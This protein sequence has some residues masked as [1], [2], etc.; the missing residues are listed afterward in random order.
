MAEQVQIKAQFRFNDGDK[1]KGNYKWEPIPMKED[2]TI[3]DGTYEPR[4]VVTQAQKAVN[5]LTVTKP[6]TEKEINEIPKEVQ[7]ELIGE[8]LVSRA[9]KKQA[10][11]LRESYESPTQRLNREKREKAS[12]MEYLGEKMEAFSTA[13]PNEMPPVELFQQWQTEAAAA[14]S[15]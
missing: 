4:C 7:G 10:D 13:N 15:K 2:G 6:T 8:C 3:E 9:K 14:A 11:K 1:S 5:F 12:K